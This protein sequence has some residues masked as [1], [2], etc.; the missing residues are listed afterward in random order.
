MNLLKLRY[1]GFNRPYFSRTHTFQRTVSES[2]PTVK[3]ICM[4]AAQQ[5]KKHV[6]KMEKK[7]YF[8]LRKS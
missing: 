3:M 5:Q 2:V 4:T 1:D 8:F 7:I 6:P